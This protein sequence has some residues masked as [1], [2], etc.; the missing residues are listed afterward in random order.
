MFSRCTPPYAHRNHLSKFQIIPSG[1]IFNSSKHFVPTRCN[2]FQIGITPA[3]KKIELVPS[4]DAAGTEGQSREGLRDK[5][6]LQ[7]RIE[8]SQFIT[9]A[10]PHT[11]D[12]LSV[13]HSIP[14]HFS[15]EWT[16]RLVQC[17][18]FS[19]DVPNNHANSGLIGGVSNELDT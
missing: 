14:G 18:F 15:E 16:D 11:P 1:D 6:K 7:T 4:W 3:N 13:N 8:K 12:L 19:N 2:L 10:T 9:R 5:N 17:P